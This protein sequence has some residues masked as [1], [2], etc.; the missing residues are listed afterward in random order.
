[1]AGSPANVYSS[2]QHIYQLWAMNNHYKSITCCCKQFSSCCCYLFLH[3][4]Y[5]YS[6][7]IWFGCISKTPLIEAKWKTLNAYCFVCGVKVTQRILIVQILQASK[8]TP[9][10]HCWELWNGVFLPMAKMMFWP[11]TQNKA[12]HAVSGL[13]KPTDSLALGLIPF[14]CLFMYPFHRWNLNP[15]KMANAC[16]KGVAAAMIPATAPPTSTSLCC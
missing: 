5:T 10:G 1:M 7:L 2:P 14:S 15:T 4:L 11:L 3:L 6:N 12:I 13:E 16:T 9:Y 8:L